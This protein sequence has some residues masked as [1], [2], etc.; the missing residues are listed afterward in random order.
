MNAWRRIKPAVYSS[1]ILFLAIFLEGCTSLLGPALPTPYPTE[2]IPTVIAMTVEAGRLATANPPQSIEPATPAASPLP[3]STMTMATSPSPTR[4]S[5]AAILLT[6]SPTPLSR[7]PQATPTRTRRPSQTP[8]ITPTPGIPFASIQISEP[9]P[10]SKII[11]PLEVSAYLQNV[12]GGY[13]ELAL[14]IPPLPE[15]SN[16]RL[17]FRKVD[18]FSSSD[19]AVWM[20]I[21]N[22]I[23]FDL[24]LAGESAQLRLSTYDRYNRPVSAS[25]VDVLLLQYGE[26]ELNP[27]G[28]LQAP[29][30]INEP[31]P[32]KL[33]QGGNLLVTGVV[34]PEGDQILHFNLITS[35]NRIVGTRDVF[36]TTSPAGS[37]TPFSTSVEYQVT[38]PTWVRMVIFELDTH[39][40]GVRQLTS[41]EVLLSP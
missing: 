34:R 33:I 38:E 27:A 31:A 16:P 41:V 24:L 15:E 36:M 29:I 30:V 32:N 10:M 13:R 22:Q 3:S 2:Y 14:Y 26:T 8:T 39:I 6:P 7:T 4:T 25:A 37:Y 35:D 17:I 20:Y 23:D 1:V 11:S 19:P 28:D 12:P 21:T 18:K 5:V 40:T 9:G